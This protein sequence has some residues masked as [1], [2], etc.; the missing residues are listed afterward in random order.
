MP[1]LIQSRGLDHL[2]YSWKL[3]EKD[4]QMTHPPSS[5]ASTWTLESPPP[6]GEMGCFSL[7]HL[8]NWTGSIAVLLCIVVDNEGNFPNIDLNNIQNPACNKL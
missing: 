7:K 3:G 6:I 5:S 8:E 2:T 1:S 4:N